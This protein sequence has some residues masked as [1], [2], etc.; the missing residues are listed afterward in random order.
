M[1]WVVVVETSENS[2]SNFT[3]TVSV[4]NGKGNQE[5]E[6]LRTELT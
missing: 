2:G 5:P 1:A 4:R 3:L 6:N